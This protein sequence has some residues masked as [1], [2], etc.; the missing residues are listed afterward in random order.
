MKFSEEKKQAIS[1]YILEKI[2]EGNPGITK[3]YRNPWIKRLKNFSK[4]N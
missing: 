4:E 3:P 2:A 1:Q